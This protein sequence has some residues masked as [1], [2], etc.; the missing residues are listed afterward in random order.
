MTNYNY[1]NIVSQ[2]LSAVL[3]LMTA[4]MGG[5]ASERSRQS[6]ERLASLCFKRNPKYDTIFPKYE[7][8]AMLYRCTFVPQIVIL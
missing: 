5:G 1:R 6:K 3:V 4:C 2:F 7:T 8:S